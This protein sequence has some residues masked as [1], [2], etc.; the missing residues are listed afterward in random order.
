MIQDSRRTRNT[1]STT[2]HNL[3]EPIQNPFRILD[4]DCMIEIL[5]YLSR[6]DI[7]NLSAVDGVMA[8]KIREVHHTIFPKSRAPA[9][10]K[11]YLR[12]VA[13][14]AVRE[15]TVKFTEPP[16]RI[17]R[18]QLHDDSPDLFSG[19]L[20]RRRLLLH[21]STGFSSGL[22]VV[23]SLLSC[24]LLFKTPD[25]MI[26]SLSDGQFSGNMH[27]YTAEEL[28]RTR[29]RQGFRRI[30]PRSTPRHTYTKR[31]RWPNP[32]VISH[33]K[34]ALMAEITVSAAESL[35]VPPVIRKKRLT[36]EG[37]KRICAQIMQK[38]G[39][40]KH[41][42]D[43]KPRMQDEE[44]EWAQPYDDCREQDGILWIESEDIS[45]GP[46]AARRIID[47]PRLTA[48]ERFQTRGLLGTYGQKSDVSWLSFWTYRDD[49]SKQILSVDADDMGV[50]MHIYPLESTSSHAT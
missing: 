49:D 33:H 13:R 2:G 20:P 8:L 40:L 48:N 4:I 9:A 36:A 18:P 15:R 31:P 44:M 21:P 19:G 39:L 28:H 35:T 45:L 50:R 43:R 26:K 37:E 14:H 42:H 32:L 17:S 25:H 1:S 41:R 12:S 46:G 5:Q 47:L 3:A 23:H 34:Q 11:S 30:F 29:S 22:E 7:V 16:R 27:V 6:E 10:R 24:R 38:K